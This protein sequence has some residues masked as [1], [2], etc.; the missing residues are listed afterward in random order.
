M[1]N[2][3]AQGTKLFWDDSTVAQ[4][5]G[6]TGST[7]STK[8]ANLIGQVV[9]FNGPT[10]SAAKIDV[11]NL[12][13]TAKEF[14]MGLRDE[15]DLSIDVMYDP[16]DVGQ[17]AMFADRGTRTRRGWIIKLSTSSKKLGG[18]GYC[19]GFAITGATD[20]S[21]KASITISITGAVIASSLTTAL[22]PTG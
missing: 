8:A 5:T 17:A 3:E 19:T 18:L 16:E 6:T 2:F 15:G 1:S 12:L 7:G 10:G 13:S 14:L 20:D 9:G 22:Y 21:I 4:T 11:T